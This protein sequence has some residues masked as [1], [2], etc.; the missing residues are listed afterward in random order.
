MRYVDLVGGFEQKDALHEDTKMPGERE[1]AA[2]MA[3]VRTFSDF[4]AWKD[5]VE[6]MGAR[7]RSYADAENGPCEDDGMYIDAVI[8]VDHGVE[9]FLP[10]EVGHFAVE[11]GE[12]YLAATPD[13]YMRF[14]Y[15]QQ[16]TEPDEWYGRSG[17]EGHR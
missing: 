3:G 1:A 9:G 10:E 17:P 7:T 8:K 14:M 5:A 4:K 15:E 6:A 11:A 12:G 16:E 13:D 2:A